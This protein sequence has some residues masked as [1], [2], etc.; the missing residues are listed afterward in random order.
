MS[1]K[2][3]TFYKLLELPRNVKIILIIF[4]DSSLCCFS[5]WFSYYLR[6]GNFLTPVDS[7]FVPIIISIVI[8]FLVF[9]ILGV[10]KNLFRVFDV[11]QIVSIS[12]AVLTYFV[13]FFLIITIFSI[14][15]VP[16]TI[17]FIQPIIYL[18]LLFAA[19]FF[20]GVLLNYQHTTLKKK[21]YVALIYGS[22]N[23][24][25]QLM[26]S[27]ENSD[28]F[29]EGFLDDNKHLHGRILN[30]KSIYNPK[31][32]NN[33]IKSKNVS[34]VLLA[35]PS[36]TRNDRNIIFKNISK[37]SV[38]VKTLPTLSD[39][40][41]GLVDITKIQEPNIEDLLGREQV[42]P[43]I[44]LME[45]NIVNKIVMVTGAGGSIGSELCRQIIKLNPEK[46]ILFENNEFALHKIISDLNEIKLRNIKL[47]HV[48]LVSLLGSISDLELVDVTIKNWK[49]SIIFHAAAYKHVSLVEQNMIEGIKNN[50][51]GT[52]NV[53][54]SCMKN[55]VSNFVLIST[56]KAVMPKNI[57]GA[58]KRLSEMYIQAINHNENYNCSTNSTIVRFGNV[59]DSSGSVIPIFKKQI[60]YGGPITLS[61]MEVTRYFM[62]IPEASLLVIQASSMVNKNQIFV[63]E[64]GKP[65]KILDLA[66]KMIR[67]S[68]L[69]AKNQDNPNG[70]IEIVIKGLTQGEKLHEDL[71]IGKN[72]ISTEHPK[73]LKVDDTLVEL[74]DLE[75]KLNELKILINQRDILKIIDLFNGL[76][77]EFN[78]KINNVD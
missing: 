32:I 60:K 47:K 2:N 37:Y 39:L 57:M 48:Q 26:N 42:E 43:K 5:I 44:D 53:F 28:I 10:Y 40:A 9:W 7:M 55:K 15:S 70:D 77:N 76:S 21:K 19:R 31:E 25:V 58:T 45:K 13:F 62:T 73:I 14:E 20:F 35:I 11:Y 36:L 16:R 12:T 72:P 74:H 78:L 66:L 29:I 50:V 23:A 41:E 61:D 22:G 59:L 71:L 1:I 65:I 64:M 54:K 30:G 34:H 3:L 24:G 49:P 46:L 17:G 8:S 63:L 18:F 51:F 67:L 33:L 38:T 4:L 69:S 75:N 27:L 68:G 6:L 56:D 52:I